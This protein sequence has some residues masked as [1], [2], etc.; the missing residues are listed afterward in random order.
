[1]LCIYIYIYIYT[2][3]LCMCMYIHTYNYMYIYICVYSIS[4]ISSMISIISSS[5]RMGCWGIT[6]DSALRDVMAL[7]SDTGKED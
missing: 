5:S 2:Y 3:I 1:M 6:E 4:I 7:T